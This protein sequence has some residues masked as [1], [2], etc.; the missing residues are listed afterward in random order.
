[1]DEPIDK[2]DSHTQPSQF[3]AP[4]KQAINIPGYTILN[5]IGE[6]PTATVWKAEQQS[7]KRSVA[8]KLLKP[9]FAVDS[10]QAASFKDLAKVVAKL[11][12]PHFIQIY[13]A[14]NTEDTAYLVMELIE[15]RTL[16]KIIE[17]D[18]AL[19]Q[20]NALTIAAAVAEGLEDAW[21]ADELSH[22][23]LKPDNIMIDHEGSVKIADLGHAKSEEFLA[24]GTMNQGLKKNSVVNYMPPESTKKGHMITPQGDMY[25]LGA[26]LYHMVTGHKPFEDM[27]LDDVPQAHIDLQIPNPASINPKVST[28]CAQIIARLMMK[29]P[30]HRFC[31]WK[32]V[33]HDLSKL[34]KGKIV[35][36]KLPASSLSTVEINQKTASGFNKS[37]A[38]IRRKPEIAR[39]QSETI[40][41]ELKEKYGRKRASKWLKIPLELAMAA[42]FGWLV[43][44][45]IGQPLLPQRRPAKTTPMPPPPAPVQPTSDSAPVDTFSLEEAQPPLIAPLPQ[46]PV[47]SSS[48]QPDLGSTSVTSIP[49]PLGVARDVVK[50]LLTNKPEAAIAT[51]HDAALGPA[52]AQAKQA[53]IDILSSDA[54]R[55]KA[56]ADAF[57][58]NIGKECNL[59]LQG[60]PRRFVVTKVE[61][62]TISGELYIGGRSSSVKRAV[63]FNVSQIDP[64][65]QSRWL[66]A[67]DSP[68]IAVAKYRL[69]MMSGDFVGA[70]QLA[71]QCGPLSDAC[72]AE[73]DARIKLLTQ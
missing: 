59:N 53:V 16:A 44:V 71:E 50:T 56:V 21:N 54:L 24:S 3:P 2:A 68:D 9:K 13:N 49:I 51:L 61:D 28:A 33:C 10:A 27:S 46:V 69:H 45:L 52:N 6:G 18:G 5:K 41:K 48:T 57:K 47:D 29:D 40:K 23:N 42:W 17:E 34:S 60:Q 26:I 38:N 1:M 62:N 66:G 20:Q 4:L 36:T 67:P 73:A 43:F 35:V 58:Q 31:T 32:R 37:A 39:K 11:K 70:L 15:G 22:G 19:S 65:E 64:S 25:S 72:V 12:S 7:L 30:K 63:E 55:S 8:I 14:G